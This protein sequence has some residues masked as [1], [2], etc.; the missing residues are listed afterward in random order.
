MKPTAP[1]PALV[2]PATSPGPV[3]PDL[4]RHQLARRTDAFTSP[5]EPDWLLQRHLDRDLSGAL[6]R[7]A[8]GRVLDVGCGGR[9]YER[10]LPAGVRYVGVDVPASRASHPDSWALAEGLPFAAGSFDLVLCTQVLEHLPDPA[11]ATAE[12][13]RV[14]RPGGVL[15]LTAPQTWCLHEEPFDYFRFTRYGLEQ[16]ARG[17]GLEAVEVR[18]Q[19]GFWAV[20]GISLIMHLGSY[21]RWVGE[22]Q[23]PPAMAPRPEGQ[24]PAWRRLLWPLRLPMALFNLCLAALDALPQPGIFAVNHLLVARKPA[25]AAAVPV[26]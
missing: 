20:A 12:M 18:R 1:P 15:V 13:A 16:L 2:V 25:G 11:T 6:A 21:A 19:G 3:R 5:L 7:F 10:R 9:P 8:S 22:R 4:Y 26:T 24:A 17:A 14:L 23:G